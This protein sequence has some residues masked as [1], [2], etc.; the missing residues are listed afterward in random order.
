LRESLKIFAAQG[1]SDHSAAV[2]TLTALGRLRDDCSR[3]K[4]DIIPIGKNTDLEVCIAHLYLR[5]L[6]VQAYYHRTNVCEG[7]ESRS[8]L[9]EMASPKRAIAGS[10]MKQTTAIAVRIAISIR[11]LPRMQ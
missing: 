3:I 4:L 9:T 7:R 2:Y 8:R 11:C 6:V 10:T 5:C 1:H